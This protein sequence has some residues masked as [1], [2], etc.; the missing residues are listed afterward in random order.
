MCPW[1]VKHLAVTVV[2]PWRWSSLAAAPLTANVQV[3]L[4]LGW[5]KARQQVA[6]S[7]YS[8]C[9]SLTGL[10]FLGVAVAASVRLRALEAR[11][12]SSNLGRPLLLEG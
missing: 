4:E 10:G 1:Q 2:A 9:W 6:E 12:L 11:G 5:A 3:S 8:H 7:R